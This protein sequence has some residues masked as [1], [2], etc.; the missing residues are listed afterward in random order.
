MTQR[1]RVRAPTPGGSPGGRALAGG[2]DE[3]PGPVGGDL[4]GGAAVDRVAHQQQLLGLHGADQPRQHR[5]QQR[6]GVLHR[7]QA[8][9]QRPRGQQRG[10]GWVFG[11]GQ[12]LLS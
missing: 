10:R 1:K 11:G 4:Q 7:Q 9:V 12:C 6:R 5:L 3:V 8:A 2:V